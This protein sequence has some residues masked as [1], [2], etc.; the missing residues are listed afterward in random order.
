M[1]AAANKYCRIVGYL[2]E[3]VDDS[4]FERFVVEGARK[5]FGPGVQPFAAGPDGGRDARFQ[6]T[7]E[8]FPSTAGPWTGT[9]IFQAKHTSGI[10]GHY[11]DADFSSDAE[12]S[13]ISP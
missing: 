3:D 4:Q 7:A 11:S 13:V 5:L 6:G 10:N 1:E 9:T 8:R 2:F 12:T